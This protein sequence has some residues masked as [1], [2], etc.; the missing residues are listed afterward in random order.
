[1]IALIFLPT[2]LAD[3]SILGF[4]RHII[5]EERRIFKIGYH[6]HFWITCDSH[7]MGELLDCKKTFWAFYPREGDVKVG[8]VAAYRIPKEYRKN[9]PKKIRYIVHR[10]INISDGCYWFKGDA[11]KYPDDVCVKKL[12][13]VLLWKEPKPWRLTI[14]G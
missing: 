8:D 5:P 3:E 2:S 13:Y 6:R 1:M 10:I 4:N 11:N 12:R 7:S 9:F 14:Y